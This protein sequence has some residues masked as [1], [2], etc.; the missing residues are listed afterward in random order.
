MKKFEVIN[1]KW[2]TK[3]EEIEE[4]QKLLDLGYTVEQ[5][6][7]DMSFVIVSREENDD[8]KSTTLLD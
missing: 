6:A 1:L 4:L 2:H 8:K 5:F 7:P 3:T